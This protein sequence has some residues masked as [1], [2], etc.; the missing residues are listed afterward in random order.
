MKIRLYHGRNNPEQ[1]M[2]DWGFESVTLDGVEGII[3]TYG[4]PRV[5][6][7][8]E[9]ALQIAK[10]LTGWDAL[11]DGLEMHVFEDLIKTNDGYFG[12]WELS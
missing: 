5:F 9:N 12:D 7:V 3:W 4:V 11:G 1:E 6:F 8:N 10:D 2:D